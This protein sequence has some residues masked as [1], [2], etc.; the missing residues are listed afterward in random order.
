MANLKK[1]FLSKDYTLHFNELSEKLRYRIAFELDSCYN[2]PNVPYLVLTL[3]YIK[4]L[5]G[6][7]WDGASPKIKFLNWF[8]GTPDGRKNQLMIPTLIHD[9]LYQNFEKQPLSRKTIDLI[10]YELMKKQDW[11]L[12]FIY[13]LAVRIFGKIYHTMKK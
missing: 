7:S 10:F 11:K 2:V 3:T 9:I 4:V 8:I 12:S 5:R 13:Y 6:F 1:Y